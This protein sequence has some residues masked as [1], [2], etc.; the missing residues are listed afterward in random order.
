MDAAD[1]IQKINEFDVRVVPVE[2]VGAEH[3]GEGI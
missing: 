3:C 1:L 2:G